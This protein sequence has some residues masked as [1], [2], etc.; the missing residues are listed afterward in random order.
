MSMDTH[1]TRLTIVA[2]SALALVIVGTGMVSAQS[3]SPSPDT[4]SPQATTV[5]L[6]GGP[7]MMN[8]Q[9]NGQD[10]H[11]RG[12]GDQGRGDRGGR[13]DPRGMGRSGHDD[14]QG[15]GQGFG[16]GGADDQGLGMGRGFDLVQGLDDLVSQEIVRLDAD[17][18]VL[19]ER[20]QHGTVTT[21]ADGSLTISLATG[22]TATVTTDANTQAYGWDTTSRPMRSEVA[23]ADIAA[24]ADV[25]VWS[26]SQSDGS[27]LASR[28]TILPAAATAAP[29]ASPAP[30]N[31][32]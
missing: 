22:D 21:N 12:W 3:S 9:G 8:G 32:G 29:S 10:M 17:G 26:Q 6:K 1:R 30:A 4:T 15:Y 18:N 11:G 28:I 24:G 23:V 2:G 27:F 16:R 5:P 13:M 14:G 25:L 20:L 7:G 31:A 19:T